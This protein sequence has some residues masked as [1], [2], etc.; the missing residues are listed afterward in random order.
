V[1]AMQMSEKYL[2]DFARFY[3]RFHQLNL[4]TFAAIEQP[5]IAL[6]KSTKQ[7]NSTFDSKS[8][9]FKITKTKTST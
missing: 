5:N 6:F 9:E 3:R 1:V 8:T 7:N 2:G 4:T